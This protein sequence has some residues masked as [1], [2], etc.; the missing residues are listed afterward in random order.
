MSI[1][2]EIN[3]IPMRNVKYLFC[4]LLVLTLMTNYSKEDDRNSPEFKL[5]E[6][7]NLDDLDYQLYSLVLKELFVN[8]E[9]LVVNQETPPLGTVNNPSFIQS[10]NG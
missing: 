7:D 6:S 1:F 5:K 3:L 10:R 9:N 8:T 2:I 4:S